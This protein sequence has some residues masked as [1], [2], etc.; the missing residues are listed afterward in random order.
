MINEIPQRPMPAP[1]KRMPLTG[2]VIFLLV[3]IITAWLI[4]KF[5]NVS[6]NAN[7]NNKDTTSTKHVRTDSL[8]P[9]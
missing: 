8:H 1:K 3:V 9:E 2:V 6:V 4:I 7:N 5:R